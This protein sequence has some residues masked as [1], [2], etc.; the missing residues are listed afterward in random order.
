MPKGEYEMFEALNPFF[1]VAG[2]PLR[3]STA[4]TLT[5]SSIRTIQKKK[6]LDA[7]ALAIP[8]LRRT[9]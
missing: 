7:T 3:V 1:E 2:Y 5:A 9:V 6:M 4:V 8:C